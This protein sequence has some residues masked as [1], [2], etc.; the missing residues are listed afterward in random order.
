MFVLHRPGVIFPMRI[1]SICLL[2]TQGY[3]RWAQKYR[4]KLWPNKKIMLVSSFVYWKIYSNMNKNLNDISW[5]SISRK[6][7]KCQQAGRKFRIDGKNNENKFSSHTK[8]K[9]FILS[10]IH[11][12][13]LLLR[14]LT[15]INLI[16]EEKKI[17][18]IIESQTGSAW[19]LRMLIPKTNKTDIYIYIF[20]TS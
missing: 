5:F 3:T 20:S 13:P 11:P 9:F 1:C 12:G 6:R 2:H 18:F 16:V 14:L 10:S 15:H 19:C 7:K 8:E 17:L 4:L